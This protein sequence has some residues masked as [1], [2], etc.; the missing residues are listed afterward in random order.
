MSG[1]LR[2]VGDNLRRVARDATH[3]FS[4]LHNELIFTRGRCMGVLEATADPL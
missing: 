1:S 4:A 2:D 3:N